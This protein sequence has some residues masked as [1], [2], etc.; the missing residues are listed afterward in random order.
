M[1][2]RHHRGPLL[3]TSRHDSELPVTPF[4]D[5]W[6]RFSRQEIIKVWKAFRN[7]LAENNAICTPHPFFLCVSTLEILPLKLEIS[8]PPEDRISCLMGEQLQHLVGSKFLL[9]SASPH[10]RIQGATAIGTCQ[11]VHACGSSDNTMRRVNNVRLWENGRFYSTSLPH[12]SLKWLYMS[13][14]LCQMSVFL[15]KHVF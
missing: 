6:L 12:C 13:L 8:L 7:S 5:K 11:V 2:T 4:S 14:S 1:Q 10:G 9:L 3:S 15:C